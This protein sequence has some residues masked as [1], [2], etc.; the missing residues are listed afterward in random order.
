MQDVAAAVRAAVIA[1]GLASRAGGL[2]EAPRRQRARQSQLTS[3]CVSQVPRSD[4]T[5]SP[6]STAGS[7]HPHHTTRAVQ[8]A[9]STAQAGH[10]HLA[11]R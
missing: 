11:C 1:R 7:H 3:F 9:L 2:G 10:A 5:L 4:I 8:F 6:A